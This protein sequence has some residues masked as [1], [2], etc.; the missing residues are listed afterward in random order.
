MACTASQCGATT[1]DLLG[2]EIVLIDSEIVR[3]GG[4][5]C[6]SEGYDLMRGEAE[7]G[8]LLRIVVT[9]VT[10]RIYSGSRRLAR[11]LLIGFA[12]TQDASNC[13]AA[14]IGDGI[15]QAAWR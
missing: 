2:L 7:L 9:E 13:V 3:L 5:H 6:D 11:A 12:E 10:V 4:K 15:I 1:N 8:G 14:I